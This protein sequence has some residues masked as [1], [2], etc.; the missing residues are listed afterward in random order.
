MPT[1]VFIDEFQILA[2]VYDPDHDRILPIT[3]YYQKPSESLVAPIVVSGSSVSL[4]LGRATSGALS[5]EEKVT[6]AWFVQVKYRESAANRC[7]VE[8][9]LKQIDTIQEVK[10]YTALTHW[11]VSKGGF[12]KPAQALLQELGMYYTDLAQF[13][14]LAKAFGFL[15]FPEKVKG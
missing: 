1:A 14:A 5:G 12:S 7:H 3:N 4:L 6:A 2:D 8:A 15:G 9:F 11:Y 10:G 13:N